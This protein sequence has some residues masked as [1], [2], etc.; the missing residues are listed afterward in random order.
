[1][2]FL[3]L[4]HLLSKKRQTILVLLGISLGTTMFLVI[5][6]V[7]MGMQEYILERMLANAPH[8]KIEPRESLVRNEPLAERF[9]GEG[10]SV[11]WVVPPSGKRGELHLE[12]PQGWFDLLSSSPEVMGY[13]PVLVVNGLALRGTV[14]AP[15]ALQGFLPERISR[16]TDFE[17]S[18]VEGKLADIAG[19]GNQL[20]VG[21][22]FLEKIG[23]VRGDSIRI[24]LGSGEPLP[25][26]IAGVYHSGMRGFDDVILYG[27]LQ[28]VQMANRTPG[29]IGAVHVYLFDPESAA[30]RANQWSV[31]S[32]DRVE[33]WDQS[34]MQFLQIFSVQNFTRLVITFAIL[35]VASFGIYN[36]LSIMVN[37]K[38]REIAILRSIG[39]PPKDV[40]ELFLLQGVMLGV[41]G[42]MVGLVVG[43]LL[44]LWIGT[45]E[46]GFDSPMG[47][48]L[49]I[50]YSPMNYVTGFLLAAVSSVAASFLPARAASKY[51][52]LDIIRSEG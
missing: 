13:S 20:V 17:S 47:N 26:R 23:A 27:A 44:N 50:S 51:T 5:A 31:L 37:Q 1:M 39:Y 28:D 36:V 2:M 25:F 18:M 45:I 52:P 30:A 19:G 16:L 29:R 4:R 21:R 24:S 10:P 33:S 43:H 3:A 32:R 15:I 8:V 40:L 12:H 11:R 38:K 46:M 6:G 41:G 34:S 48:R 35:I 49:L 7:Q 42:A 9:Y 14:R 22:S